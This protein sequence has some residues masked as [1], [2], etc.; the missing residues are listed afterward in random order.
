[1]KEVRDFDI[2]GNAYRVVY[3]LFAENVLGP[4]LNLDYY[5]VFS[6]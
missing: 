6:S 2:M 1:M 4:H 5:T 3:L